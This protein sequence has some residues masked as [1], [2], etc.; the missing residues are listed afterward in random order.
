MIKLYDSIDKKL[1]VLTDKNIVN[2]Y[3]CGPTV[4]NY[5][6]IGNARP[7]VVMDVLHRLLV[8]LKYQ[9]NYVHN[10]TDVD[11][12]IINQAAKLN[13]SEKEVSDKY[14]S[15]YL[16]DLKTMN[17][18]IPNKMP[19]VSN[20]ISQIIEFVMQL[21][22]KGNAY[23]SNNDVYFKIDSISSYGKLSKKNINDLIST[24]RV[25]N[26]SYK[27]NINDFALWK[28]T[29]LGIKWQSP[30][31][32][33]RPGWHT[34]C[35]VFIE[36]LFNQQTIDVHAGGV[37]LKFPHHEN[38]RA[39][40]LAAYDK[41]LANIWWHNGHVNFNNEKM[42]KSL[43]NFILVKDFVENHSGF[44]LRYLLLNHDHQQPINFCD[45]LISEAKIVIKKYQN[46]LKLWVYNSFINNK[47]II[48]SQ[49]FNKKYYKEIVGC[50]SNNV[51]T[52]NTFTLINSMVKELNEAIKKNDYQKEKQ[53][54]FNTLVFALEVLG[55]Q[56]QYGDYSHEQKELISKWLKTK[57]EKDYQTAD[58]IRQQLQDLN[59][60]PN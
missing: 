11:D 38:E 5:I 31:N 59:I 35:V 36:K 41:E 13:I 12:K 28:T 8:H 33:G 14:L 6:H 60:L 48:K 53:L 50:L 47:E 54:I 30:W 46:I 17:V 51:D 25:N 2:I 19:K 27:E 21:V 44:V 7:V 29:D 24:E 55:F 52:T 20:Y 49:E 16:Q 18:L 57:Q 23:V 56:F 34:E 42:S 3:L 4:Y 22:N 58:L 37:D 45:E 10:I 1:K 26:S 43:N 15:A 39:Q 40:F 9:I 32:I